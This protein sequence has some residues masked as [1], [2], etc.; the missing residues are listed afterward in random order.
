M[1]NI[2]EL[3]TKMEERIINRLGSYMIIVERKV[4]EV[5]KRVGLFE[6]KVAATDNSPEQKVVET[7]LAEEDD[8]KNQGQKAYDEKN[9]YET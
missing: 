4:Q 7:K 9:T 8:T 1:A 2:M 5:E 6:A 3:I